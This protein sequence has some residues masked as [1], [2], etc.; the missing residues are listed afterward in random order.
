MTT[1]ALI[2]IALGA[3]LI[4]LGWGGWRA[5]A[6]IGWAAGLA[7]LAT[8]AQRDGAWGIAIGM[9]AAIAAMIAILLHAG[10]T[11]PARASRPPREAPAVTLPHRRSDIAHRLAVFALV[12][13]GAFVAAQWLAFAAQA[14][15]RRGGAGDADAIVLAL[16][17]QPTLWGVIMTVQMTRA[18]AR[19]MIA[20]P[21]VAGWVG[22]LLWVMS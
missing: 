9:V 10:W 15:A 6:A 2:A 12:V 14:L 7:G 8:L 5:A 20:P 21:L 3:L 1:I 11:A 13:P 18:D 16:F 19:G 4:R 22:T 17:L